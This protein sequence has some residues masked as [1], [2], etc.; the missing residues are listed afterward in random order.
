MLPNSSLIFLLGFGFIVGIVI[1]G[2]YNRSKL[3]RCCRSWLTVFDTDSIFLRHV[4][5][6]FGCTGSGLY[7]LMGLGFLLILVT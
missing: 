2:D 1:V 7:Y 4:L 3:T 5:S 6:G